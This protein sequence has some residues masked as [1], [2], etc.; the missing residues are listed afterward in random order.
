MIDYEDDGGGGGLVALLFDVFAGG[1]WDLLLGFLCGGELYD[2]TTTI[3]LAA[4]G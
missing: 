3:R 1:L 2:R 4:M